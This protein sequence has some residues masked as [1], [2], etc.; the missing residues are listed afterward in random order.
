MV[1]GDFQGRPRLMA[2]MS[3]ENQYYHFRLAINSNLDPISHRLATIHLLQT[4]DGRTDRRQLV[5][6]ARPPLKYACRSA[7]NKL[8]SIDKPK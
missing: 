2:F 3:F 1:V 7:K 8:K 5:P 6:W 4:E